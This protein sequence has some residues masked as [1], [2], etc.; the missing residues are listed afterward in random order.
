MSPS[1]PALFD[2]RRLTDETL[3]ALRTLVVDKIDP[4]APAL[5]KWLYQW[6]DVEQY[7]RSRDPQRRPARHC[8]ALPNVA[9]WTDADFGD[10]IYICVCLN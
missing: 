5:G 7:W 10:A 4:A 9:G 6:A 3:L 2:P 1:P 8:L